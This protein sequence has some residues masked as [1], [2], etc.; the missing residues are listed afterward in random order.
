VILLVSD[1]EALSGSLKAALE[2]CRQNGIIVSVV[3]VGSD[4]GGILDD[5]EIVSRRDSRA[6]RNAA[7]Q[8]GGVYIDG[9]REDA[10]KTLA[11]YLRSLSPGSQSRG[12]QKERKARWF[13][14]VM[15]AIITFGASKWCLLRL[16]NGAPKQA[17]RSGVGE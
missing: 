3:A 15:S 11:G 6:M 14:F 1:G 8:A 17:P 10:S 4:E 2:R 12:T 16:G 7:G 13:I 5:G 9:N